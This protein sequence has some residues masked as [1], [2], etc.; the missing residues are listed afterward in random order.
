MVSKGTF[1]SSLVHPHEVLKG[2]ILANAK[3]VIV[4]H[5]HLSGDVEPSDVDKKSHRCL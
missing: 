4:A 1:N 2:T 3:S 5:N